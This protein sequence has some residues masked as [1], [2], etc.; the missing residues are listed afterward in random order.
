MSFFSVPYIVHK[1]GTD[2]YG[3]LMTAGIA[4]SYL[5]FMDLGLGSATTKYVAEHA[6]REEWDEVNRILWTSLGAYLVLGSLAALALVLLTPLFVYQWLRIPPQLQ[7]TAIGVFYVSALGFLVGMVNNVPTAIP[8]A[9]H[10]FD[11]VNRI[12]A[13]VGTVQTVLT[14]ILVAY[15]YSVR[16]VVIG[17]LIVAGAALGMNT[18]IARILLPR[19]TTPVWSLSSFLRLIRFGSFVTVSGVVGPVLSQFEKVVLANQISMSALTYYTAPFNLVT[20][21]SGFSGAFSSA[22]FPLFSS[23]YGIGRANTNIDINMRVSRYVVLLL[24]I[25]VV[26]FVVFGREFLQL[27]IGPEFARNSTGA[28]QILALA[29]LVNAAA[30]SP[31]ALIQA[32]GRP[33]LTAK[34]HLTELI[35]H[36]PLTFVLVRYWG[37]GG[38]ACA[39]F[40]RVVLDTALI[41]WAMIRLYAQNW[42]RWLRELSSPALGVTVASGVI[43]GYVRAALYGR[44]PPAAILFGLG[45][46]FLGLACVAMWRWGLRRDEH[47]I[48][49]SAFLPKREASK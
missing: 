10:R 43:L 32:S 3:L 21:L 39:W 40:L 42:R 26:F 31:F 19:W 9:L 45:G 16:E 36:V 18:W 23:L 14:V 12:G 33:D 47:Q 15:G 6:A 41:Y 8:R 24:V 29:T 11:V 2:T 1:L 34:F 4:T 30:W 17:N 22:L 38:A 20:R 25:P 35:V 5:W 48:L 28:L 46:L 49:V 7:H 37:V 27:W 13:A 44:V